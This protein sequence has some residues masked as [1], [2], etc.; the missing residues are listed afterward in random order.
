MHSKVLIAIALFA[1]VCANNDLISFE[2]DNYSTNDLKKLALGA[3]KYHRV[4]N[5]L[6]HMKGGLHDYIDSLSDEKIIKIIK[7]YINLYPVLESKAFFE[8]IAQIDRSFAYTLPVLH[9]L[10]YL[11]RSTLIK[12]GE[13]C[14]QYHRQ[15]REIQAV[16][17][18]HDIAKTL[19]TQ[20]LVD[21]VKACLK[22]NPQLLENDW[23]RE[24]S[25]VKTLT[26][27]EINIMLDTVDADGL[28]KI[29]IA[30]DEYDRSESSIPRVGGLVD[31]VERLD[32]NERRT[33]IISYTSKYEKLREQ[34]FIKILLKKYEKL[35]YRSSY[36]GVSR[37]LY[38]IS[39]EELERIALEFETYHRSKHS[40]ILT[41]G[42]HDYIE[43]LSDDEVIEA[44]R[45]F[46]ENNI[47]LNDA[48]VVRSVGK[49]ENKF[50]QEIEKKNDEDLKKICLA[51]EA[52]ERK[53]KGIFPLGGLHDYINK[54]T[55][56]DLIEYIRLKASQYPIIALPS[57][58][59]RLIQN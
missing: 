39:R 53:I 38:S 31:Y 26:V 6:T 24:I 59:E 2:L 43:R 45:N 19:N 17:G 56:K 42:L 22:E 16:G 57:Q 27:E 37:I 13:T 10:K 46:I 34:G 29:A 40:L 25:K 32:Q 20:E 11:S 14:E 33:I 15:V 5:D 51:L 48:E 28:A 52:Y 12:Y 47:E 9:S 23:I 30:C 50:W 49:F 58:L 7:D 35:E 44:I 55:R 54:L 3:E 41:G 21:A 36:K 1:L 4:I 18:F 8:E